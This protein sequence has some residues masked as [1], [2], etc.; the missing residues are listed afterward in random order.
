MIAQNSFYQ[1]MDFWSNITV[2][3]VFKT[4]KKTSRALRE[5]RSRV[6]DN[7]ASGSDSKKN[8][9]RM[10]K[11][12]RLDISPLRENLKALINE[13]AIRKSKIRFGLVTVDFSNLVP[14][15]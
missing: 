10:F 9:F 5:K 11:L 13:E 7:K 15:Q 12:E 14:Q 3:Q 4:D 8:R 1:A 2:D 6:L